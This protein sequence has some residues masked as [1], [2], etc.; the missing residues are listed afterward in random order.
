MKSLERNVLKVT[1][2]NFLSTIWTM[3]KYFQ[4]WVYI[5]FDVDQTRAMQMNAGE[6]RGFFIVFLA[7]L[8]CQ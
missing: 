6:Y 5:K 3:Q 2:R 8:N 1:V 7:Q 4:A